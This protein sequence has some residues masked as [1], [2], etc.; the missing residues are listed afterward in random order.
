MVVN[1]SV[2]GLQENKMGA[3]MIMGILIVVSIIFPPLGIIIIP[4]IIMS[5]LVGWAMRSVAGTIAEPI[6][7][8]MGQ[9]AE[10]IAQAIEKSKAEAWA[11]QYGDVEINKDGNLRVIEEE[12]PA[13]DEEDPETAYNTIKTS[14]PK[15]K[16]KKKK[17]QAKKPKKEKKE[18][19]LPDATDL[20]NDI[21]DELFGKDK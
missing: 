6:R 3:W 13:I 9:S 10:R 18:E 11:S 1:R 8:G 17:P 15:K 16:S 7:D 4:L 21:E 14:P 5:I 12:A 19:G 20:I 2:G